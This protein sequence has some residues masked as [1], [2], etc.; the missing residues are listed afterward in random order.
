MT[1]LASWRRRRGQA[2]ISERLRALPAHLR[3]DI[4]LPEIDGVD[5]AVSRHLHN[6][7]LW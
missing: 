5:I 1:L 2:A 4:G 3:R 6:P 7:N